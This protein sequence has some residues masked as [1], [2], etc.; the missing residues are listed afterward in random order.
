MFTIKYSQ[1]LEYRFSLDSVEAPLRISEW[2]ITNKLQP[3][4]ILDICAGCGVMG[5][6]LAFHLRYSMQIDFLEIQK[7]YKEFFD[8]NIHRFQSQVNKW[9]QSLKV[10][11]LE[12]NYAI[13]K[14]EIYF[15]KYDLIVCNPPYFKKDEGALSPNLF[16]NR[17]RFFLDEEPEVLWDAIGHCLQPAGN[18]F[19]LARPGMLP[20][21]QKRLKYSAVV[22][23]AYD[24]RGTDLIHISK[25]VTT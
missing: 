11:W 15:Q 25:N 19:I 20:D 24:I 17:C 13:L 6:E 7:L 5:L 21:I 18:A 14:A 12:Q 2:I 10:E 4:K 16:K 23:K 22:Q 8:Q 3:K 1:P 9:G